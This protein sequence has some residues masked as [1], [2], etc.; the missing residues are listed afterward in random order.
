MG[1]IKRRDS[2]YVEFFVV[3]DGSA[4][5]LANGGGGQLKR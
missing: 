5:K 2:Y 4:L 3:D 1:L